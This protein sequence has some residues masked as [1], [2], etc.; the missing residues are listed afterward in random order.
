MIIYSLYRG[1]IVMIDE[2]FKG[3]DP[4]FVKYEYVKKD[5]LVILNLTDD[6]IH[7]GHL[8]S[9]YNKLKN[10]K[11]KKISVTNLEINIDANSFLNTGIIILL[12]IILAKFMNSRK[13]VN[14]S[15][16]YNLKN[17]RNIIYSVFY[18]SY[19]K[20]YFDLKIK[21]D[22]FINKVLYQKRNN[23]YVENFFRWIL[24]PGNDKLKDVSVMSSEL[25]FY[26]NVMKIDEDLKDTIIEVVSELSSNACEHANAECVIYCN[27]QDAYNKNRHDKCRLV[28][29]LILN[30]SNQFLYSSL[31]KKFYD[32]PDRIPTKV[33]DAYNYHKK[34]FCDEYDQNCFFIL[35]VFQN[36]ITTRDTEDSGTGGTGLTKFIQS[37]EPL[38]KDNFCSLWT[39][40]YII[41][42]EKEYIG[43]N[44]KEIGF[45][46]TGNYSSDIPDLNVINNI[47]TTL[48]GTLYNV[49]LD[50]DREDVFYEDN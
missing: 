15:F 17:K 23:Y 42:F 1:I 43:N 25:E 29:I 5:K 14:I 30:I 18:E 4:Q 38:V 19:L 34:C 37:V 24:S 48:Q 32:N 9:L 26:L 13:D 36:K 44:T 35:S 50:I 27:I 22:D 3:K 7:Y 21:Y 49:V 10:V 47:G 11:K 40:K 46:K 6:F 31:K 16:N 28:N 2:L 45:N 8:H 41:W 20:D 12:E 33:K 39:D